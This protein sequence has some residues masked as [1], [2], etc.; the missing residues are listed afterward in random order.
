MGDQMISLR[1]DVE[2]RERL[3]EQAEKRGWNRSELI[4]RVLSAW[5]EQQEGT[6]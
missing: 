5:C 3:S 2:L 4:R 1:L 6:R